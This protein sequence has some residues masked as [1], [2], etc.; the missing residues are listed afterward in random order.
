MT[1]ASNEPSPD[2]IIEGIHRIRQQLL[3]E[4]GGDLR[5][6]F[7]AAC[8]RQQESGR[9]VVSRPLRTRQAPSSSKDN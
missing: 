7:D 1:T 3:E 6:Y 4:H 9:P 2:A 8:K 5:A